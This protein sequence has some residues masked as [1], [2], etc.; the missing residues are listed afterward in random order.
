MPMAASAN[1]ASNRASLSQRASSAAT[2]AANAAVL[3]CS[4]SS[5]VRSRRRLRVPGGQPAEDPGEP[6]PGRRAGTRVPGRARPRGR[7]CCCSS[8]SMS[9]KWTSTES[10]HPA[11][12]TRGVESRRVRHRVQHVAARPSRNSQQRPASHRRRGWCA[13]Q[14]P[15][16]ARPRSAGRN[17]PGARRARSIPPAQSGEPGVGLV[18]R[19][20]VSPSSAGSGRHIGISTTPG[21]SRVVDANR[22]S[23]SGRDRRRMAFGDRDRS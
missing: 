19:L 13:R 17:A 15:F 5:R 2:R 10:R 1:T 12:G 3:I 4:C 6:C 14:R 8:T 18:D 22:A 7:R 9:A 16:H 23:T 20:P 21:S 11:T